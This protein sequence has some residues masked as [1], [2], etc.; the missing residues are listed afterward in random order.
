MRRFIG[1][2]LGNILAL[3]LATYFIAGIKY[4][5]NWQTLIVAGLILGVVNFILKPIISLI[6]LPLI[7]LSLGF[8]SIIINALM[9]YIVAYFV[10]GLKIES[11]L[12][13]I[14]GAFLI[15]II[16]ILINSLFKSKK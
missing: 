14:L 1:Q 4:D 6:S 16:N 5:N 15:S 13:A 8:F 12:A 7:I 10:E 3:W 9:L 2:I 11:F